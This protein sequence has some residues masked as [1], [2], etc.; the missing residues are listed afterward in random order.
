MGSRQRWISLACVALALTLTPASQPA[1]PGG[2]GLI[3]FWDYGDVYVVN[4][5][6]GAARNLTEDLEGFF[7]APSWSPDGSK[8]AFSGPEL[9]TGSFRAC[10]ECSVIYTMN[11]DGSGKK[12]LARI[13]GSAFAYPAWSPDGKR[14]AYTR[15]SSIFVMNADGSGK[16]QIRDLP[17][18]SVESP[19]WSPDATRIAFFGERRRRGVAVGGGHVYVMNV[20]GTAVR[21]LVHGTARDPAWSPDGA[22]IVLTRTDG[23]YSVAPDGSALARLTERRSDRD[24]A[25]SPDGRRIAFVSERREGLQLWVMNAPGSCATQLTHFDRRSSNPVDPDWQPLPA[26]G[27]APAA[28]RCGDIALRRVARQ[29][30]L[31]TAGSTAPH[32]FV[33]ANVGN[34]SATNVVFSG[35]HTKGADVVDARPSQGVC[36]ASR[37]VTCTLGTLPPGGSAEVSVDVRLTGRERVEASFVAR[38]DSFDGDLSNNRT[39]LAAY[40]CTALGTAAAD[41]LVGTAGRD[42][43]CGLGGRDTIRGRARNDLILGGDGSDWIL[44][45]D[46]ND[47]LRGGGGMD[48]LVGGLANDVIRGGDGDDA[49][50]GEGGH[51]L[52][53][54][55]PGTDI[56]AGGGGHDVFVGGAGGDT[57]FGGR[58]DDFFFTVGGMRDRIDGGPGENTALFDEGWD[59]VRSVARWDD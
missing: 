32:L 52:L 5:T 33:V 45:G 39:A 50:S 35:G 16:R 25:W 53:F 51:D 46:G 24:P 2:N 27:P 54:D 34:D 55:G 48:A 37:P 11:A 36:S 40:V 20:D 14:L 44:G 7:G 42:V 43:L 13:R 9:S 10:R 18:I 22:R 23:I 19:V 59:R 26:G 49:I 38:T 15:K 47:R 58:G 4:P 21:R 6:G 17:G 30:T 12:R 41:V 28:I 56:A 1:Y 57:F 8:L 3:A 29:P 31:G